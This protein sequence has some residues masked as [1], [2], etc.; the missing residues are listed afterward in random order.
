MTL[1]YVIYMLFLKRQHIGDGRGIPGM[2]AEE[3]VVW[4]DAL[5]P[6]PD[7]GDASINLYLG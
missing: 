7:Y 6:Y 3:G 2:R 1:S 4:G 5:I